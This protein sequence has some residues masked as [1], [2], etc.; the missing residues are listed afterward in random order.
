MVRAIALA[1]VA[2]ALTMATPA[3]AKWI[4]SWSA[5]PVNPIGAFGPFPATPSYSNRTF[6]QTV[7]LSAGGSAFRLRISNAY[8]AEPLEIGAARVAILDDAGKEVAGSSRIIRFAGSGKALIEKGA[9]IV[10]DNVTLPVAPLARLSVSLY[11]PG[12]TGPCT[13]H[14][15]AMDE[16]EISAPGDHSAAPFTAESKSVSRIAL[17]AIEVDAPKGAQ[18]LV[19]LGDSIS[20]GVGSTSGK[21]RRWP[22]FLAER[23]AKRGGTAWGVANQ[24]ISGNRV[25]QDG[26]GVSALAR[27][28]RDVIAMPGVS[29]MILFEGINDINI[30]LGSSAGPFGA[31]KSI[32]P[33]RKISADD[34][35]A[36]YRQII[37]RAHA[38]GI[39]VFGATIAPDKGLVTWTAE[40]EAARQKVNAFIRTGGAFDAV[41]DFDKVFADPADPAAIRADY[42]MGD[43]LHGNDASYRAVAD[44][45]DLGLFGK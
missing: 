39:R 30:A 7:R 15:T 8:G 20:D 14:Q 25:L 35:I 6:R 13:C 16:M 22:D 29:A 37:A 38:Q 21:N 45:I 36:A 33:S 12:D 34:M 9:L 43:H 41:L 23:L 26:M 4:T 27:F 24:G 19:V 2:A 5:A 10:S 28:D 11:L 44:S 17:A 3:E 32:L 42:H 40:G 18:T 1:L 31:A